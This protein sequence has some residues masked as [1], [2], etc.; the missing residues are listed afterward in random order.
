MTKGFRDSSSATLRFCK[1][2][3]TVQ[4]VRNNDIN[5]LPTAWWLLRLFLHIFRNISI[6]VSNVLR[7][8]C[9]GG[10]AC[11]WHWSK[12][13]ASFGMQT[14]RWIGTKTKQS[15]CTLRNNEMFSDSGA[16]Q[17]MT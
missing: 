12:L 17:G 7:L 8:S 14:R 1:S 10:E 3:P 5:V 13:A 11:A 4:T 6:F 9:K 15:G 16:S 2:W